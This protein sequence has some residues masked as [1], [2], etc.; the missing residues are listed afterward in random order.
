MGYYQHPLAKT[1]SYT[2][3]GPYVG[4]PGF[5]SVLGKLGKGL[6]GVG[7]AVLPGGSMVGRAVGAI[8]KVSAVARPA[9]GRVLSVV[10]AHPVLSAAGAAA[11]PATGAAAAAIGAAALTPQ[12]SSSF[13]TSFAISSTE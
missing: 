11:Q 5:L 8:S 7:G 13:F 9:A 12:S 4:D 2:P 3:R 1:V 6:L 10:K